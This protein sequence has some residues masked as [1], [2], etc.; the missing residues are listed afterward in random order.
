[1]LIMI[2]VYGSTDLLG[3]CAQPVPGAGRAAGPAAG[4][5]GPV[6]AAVGA[7]R[8]VLQRAKCP[9]PETGGVELQSLLPEEVN[10]P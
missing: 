6:A 5:G 2:Q 7:A 9:Q 4:A 3:P 1:M 10:S 8:S